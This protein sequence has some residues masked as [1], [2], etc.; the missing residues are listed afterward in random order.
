LT[1]PDGLRAARLL[2]MVGAVTRQA[3]ADRGCRRV[4]LLDDASPEAE[5]AARWFLAALGEERVL[6]VSVGEQEVESVLQILETEPGPDLAR[7]RPLARSGSVD[8]AAELRRMRARLI[9][10]TLPAN[11][12]NKTALLLGGALPPEPLLPLGDLY[13][14]EIR[15]LTGDWSA[16]DPVRELAERCG[17]I[18]V[19]DA[20]L[21]ECFDSRNPGGLR[22]L[23]PAARCAVE[24]ALERGRAARMFG[25]IVP[26]VGSRTLG[27]DLFE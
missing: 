27:V 9:P 2:E 5:L 21:R 8:T 14:S 7:R 13:A 19:L 10:D 20:A 12:A 4:A 16:P 15:E 17:G 11:P 22:I 26:K 24:D 23:E 25:P 18:E 6:R 3:L 1:P